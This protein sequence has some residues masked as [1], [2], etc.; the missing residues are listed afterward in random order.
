MRET[1]T[2]V[3]HRANEMPGPV[4]LPH[5]CPS[6]LSSAR[7]ISSHKAFEALGP[8]NFPVLYSF[9]LRVHDLT[10]LAGF[11]LSVHVYQCIVF[12]LT[13]T[14]SFPLPSLPLDGLP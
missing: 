14:P 6:P 5:P 11:L 10:S 9:P 8:C 3:M 12:P 2:V 4:R 13:Y 7:A 1:A